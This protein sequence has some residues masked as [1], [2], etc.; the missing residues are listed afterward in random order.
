MLER[1]DVAAIQSVAAL[2][3]QALPLGELVQPLLDP[4]LDLGIVQQQLGARGVVVAQLVADRQARIDIV[5]RIERGDVFVVAQ[6]LAHLLD[7]LA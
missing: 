2:D 5:G 6:D 1:G 4:A 3:H 7:R